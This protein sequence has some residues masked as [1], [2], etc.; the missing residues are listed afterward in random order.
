MSGYDR[1]ESDRVLNS[2]PND[3][4]LAR[5]QVWF[6]LHDHDLDRDDCEALI[7]GAGLPLPPKSSCTF[8][9]ANTMA[10]WKALRIEE[11][12]R[13][14]EAVAISRNAAATITTPDVVGMLRNNPP[15]Q[16]QLHEW[17]DGAY[18][19]I[20]DEEGETAMPCDCAL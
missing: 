18:G 13:F 19:D 2:S 8:C 10:E 16:R 12:D 4:E 6:P 1:G 3:W 17:A 14:E 7:V 20:D 9:P 11:P 5:F 15:G